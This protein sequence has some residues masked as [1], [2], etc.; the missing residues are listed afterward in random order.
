MARPRKNT[1]KLV[2]TLLA[3]PRWF[4]QAEQ[5]TANYVAQIPD[6]DE[7]EDLIRP[8][9]WAHHAARVPALAMITCFDVK[10]RWEA[11]LRVIEKGPTY[12]RVVLLYSVDYEV[13]VRNTDEIDRIKKLYRIESQ[14]QNGWRVIDPN[15]RELV[16]GLTTEGDANE[17]VD[18]LLATMNR[19]AA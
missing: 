8:D 1:P 7:I 15:G 14:G 6:G 19:A 12:L 5:V 16:A 17:F 10:R 18:K 9:Y 2:K 4:Q 3:G 13:E 11:V